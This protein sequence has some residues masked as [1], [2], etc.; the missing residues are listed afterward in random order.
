MTDFSVP[1][2]MSFGAF[3]IYFLKYFRIIFNA[4]V[5]YL[6]FVIIKSD[7]GLAHI[8][9]N[10]AML[11]GFIVA[12]ALILASMAFFQIKFHVEDGNIIYRHRLI[13]RA[14]T[15]I[16]LDRVHTLRTRQGLFYSLLNLRGVLFDTLAAK[17][18][19]IELILSESEWRSLLSRIELQEKPQPDAASAAPGMPPPYVPS[20]SKKFST[21]ELVMDALCQNHLKGMAVMGGFAA[22]VLNRL[23]DLPDNAVEIMAD[24]LETH[25]GSFAV[26]VGGLAVILAATY[27]FSLLFWLG[28]VILRYFDL[29]LTYD[30]KTL[31]FSHGLF[32]RMT[33]RFNRH[34]ICSV[35][36][37]RNYLEKRYGLSTIALRQARNSSAEKE[38]DN[39]K[40]YGRDCSRFFLEWW[41]GQEYGQ[42]SDIA[43]AESG[44]G[45]I[46]RS[47]LPDVIVSCAAAVVMWHFGLYLWLI[48]PALYLLAVIPK[49]ILTMRHSRIILRESYI[50]INMGRFAEISNYLKYDNV[51]V[52]RITR[53]PFTRF[54]G[55][56]TLSL[57]T[58]GTT[59][60]VRSLREDRAMRIYELLLAPLEH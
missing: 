17:G 25:Y 1:Q 29:T 56:V 59:F 38:D 52:V 20:L 23:S 45:V 49:G 39:L 9:L 37:K 7:E 5:I 48:L 15:T 18:E 34:K 13:S 21:G 32:S 27:I 47:L 40:I 36:V 31:T 4:T 10:T 12:L 54:T 8:L 16:P 43:C 58:T 42:E 24:Y 6:I 33:S 60:A 51:E 3:V 35:W 28:K 22:V 2:R 50:V 44:K 46:A 14:T 11:I 26:S 57:S 41:L 19:E 53:T 55:R 30:N